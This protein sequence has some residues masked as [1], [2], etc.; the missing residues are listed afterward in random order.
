MPQLNILLEARGPLLLGTGLAVGNVQESRPY[1]AGSAWRGA[2]ARTVL[3]ARGQLKHNGRPVTDHVPSPDFATVFLGEEA[4]RFGFLYPVRSAPA[5]SL[6]LPLTA[7]TC[8]QKPGFAPDG[9]GMY[10]GLLNRLREAALRG[11]PYSFGGEA[12]PKCKGRLK[13]RRGFMSRTANGAATYG[14]VRPD[15]RAFVR[16]GLN[17]YTETAQ[18]Q[19]LYL[20][21]ALTPPTMDDKNAEPFLTFA[22]VWQGSEEQE[23]TLRAWLDE[24]LLPEDGG[25]RLEVGTARARGMGH[26]ILRLPP[27]ED[28]IPFPVAEDLAV[29][30]ERFQPMADARPADPAH[31]YAALTLRSPV[32]IL[33][34]RGLPAERIAADLLRAYHS[35]VPPGLEVLADYSVLERETWTGWS[36]A[37]GLPKPVMTVISAGSV[38]ALR[39]P[40][41][42]RTQLLDYLATLTAEGLGEHRAEGLGEVLVCDPFHVAFDEG[43][44]S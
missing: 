21:E 11:K 7:R 33:D 25:Y 29:R 27:A 3:Q 44:R 13:R 41:S 37:W 22:G 9:D 28:G 2:L 10:D 6:P 24:Y 8:K 4:A 34:V 35:N 18:E 38:I 32:A 15:R 26:A 12:C 30:L 14:E 42:E 5:V 31:L 1:V 43:E 40:A 20:L 39:A 36:A 17:R 23:Q 16:V 19:I